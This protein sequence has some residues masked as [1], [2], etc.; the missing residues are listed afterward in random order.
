MEMHSWSMETQSAEY[1][2]NVIAGSAV[3]ALFV[4]P[5]NRAI[6]N[7]SPTRGTHRLQNLRI[8]VLLH[9]PR[10]ES[11]DNI[12][13]TSTPAVVELRPAPGVT[14]CLGSTAH[15]SMKKTLLTFKV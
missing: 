3:R 10:R 15:Q 13:T 14:R 1:S 11:S 5:R 9:Q 6:A 2:H 12:T 8:S 4:H 7:L